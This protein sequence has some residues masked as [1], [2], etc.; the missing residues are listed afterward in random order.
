MLVSGVMVGSIGK[1]VDITADH[2]RKSREVRWFLGSRGGAVFTKG[3]HANA[4]KS[5]EVLK[6]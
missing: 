3:S 2:L 1:T 6:S 5:D 4:G